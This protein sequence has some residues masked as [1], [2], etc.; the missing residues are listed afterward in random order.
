MR[1]QSGYIN[2]PQASSLMI[3]ALPDVQPKL[4]AGQRSDL[5]SGVTIKDII[6]K[7]SESLSRSTMRPARARLGSKNQRS[8]D[9]NVNFVMK[10][11]AY[12]TARYGDGD[13]SSEKT[14]DAT[15]K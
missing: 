6:L 8:S 14:K 3:K 7:L 9:A 5:V 4:Q 1:A 15:T 10:V 13:L 2:L 12:R 11:I